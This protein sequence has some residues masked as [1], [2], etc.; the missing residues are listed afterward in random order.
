[1]TSGVEAFYK[2]GHDNDHGPVMQT[3]T[4]NSASSPTS[5]GCL[6]CDLDVIKVRETIMDTRV[7]RASSTLARLAG[8]LLVIGCMGFFAPERA[9][10]EAVNLVVCTG[11]H[12]GTFSPGL[13]NASQPINV[14]T[15]SSWGTCVLPLGTSASSSQSFQAPLSCNALLQNTTDVTWIITWGDGET[16]TY[17]F[18]A[19]YND[20]GGL[21]KTVVGIGEIVAGRYTGST[22]I[23]TY[24]LF[25]LEL[26]ACATTTGVTSLS[27]PSTLTIIQ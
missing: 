8:V 9:Q 17:N 24:V 7:A 5:A 11:T 2:C 15:T 20:T 23:T 1:M 18:D 22:A 16:S 12:T 4:V 3:V 19:T 21:N 26:N 13:T 6:M 14:T 25:N 27:G 10:A